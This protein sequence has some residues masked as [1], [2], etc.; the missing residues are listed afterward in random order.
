MRVVDSHPL[1]VCDTLT[2]LLVH[3]SHAQG[4]YLTN[5]PKGQTSQEALSSNTCTPA[6][7]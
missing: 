4:T 7:I 2:A 6:G 1:L 3:V 5:P